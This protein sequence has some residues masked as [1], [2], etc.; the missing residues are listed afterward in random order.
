MPRS[1]T[2]RASSLVFALLAPAIAAC[3]Q[4]G[5]AP[6]DRD[7][8]QREAEA[9]LNDLHRLAS[10]AD[11]EAY[12]QLFTP[13]AVFMGTDAT[14]RWSV[15][16][17]RGYA[18]TSSGWTYQVTERHL[19]LDEDGRTAWFDERLENASYGETRGTG[20]LL[21]TEGGWKITQYNLSIPVP[22][23][24]ARE[25]VDRIRELEAGG[26]E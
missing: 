17:F 25:V 12:F 1:L 22:N 18:A 8:E 21:R 10:E 23:E 2:R 19:F 20:V 11:F 24:L 26:G 5:S 3:S 7:A 13:D 14:E 4:P 15:D 9:V 6:L 16:D